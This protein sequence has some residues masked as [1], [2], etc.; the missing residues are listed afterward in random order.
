MYF[1]NLNVD[2]VCRTLVGAHPHWLVPDIYF[3]DMYLCGTHRALPL[4]DLDNVYCVA[5]THETDGN[6]TSLNP[7]YFLHIILPE[8]V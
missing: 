1:H 2:S 8:S 3:V 6:L 4:Q 7:L 5:L